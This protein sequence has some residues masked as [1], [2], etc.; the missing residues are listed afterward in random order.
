MMELPVFGLGVIGCGFILLCAIAA[1]AI[2]ALFL[3]LGAK[4]TGVQETYSKAFWAVF[5]IGILNFFVQIGLNRGKNPAELPLSLGSFLTEFVVS[6]LLSLIVGTVM[7]TW[8]YSIP[9][10]RAMLAYAVSLVL[11][12]LAGLVLLAMLFGI[13]WATVG[14]DEIDEVV[15]EA[16]Q[17][18]YEALRERAVQEGLDP[19]SVAP[20][21]IPVL[22]D[23]EFTE[24]ENAFDI[25][26]SQ[27]ERYIGKKVR[28]VHGSRR[29]SI[30]TLKEVTGTSLVVSVKIE[31]GRVE[32]P[33]QKSKIS[34]FQM[35]D[36]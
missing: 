9:V 32:L 8:I 26:V 29:E 30:G 23:V 28:I 7:V 34:T 4:M 33:I 35:I 10:L 16:K 25:E 22:E 36:D 20:E 3:H 14:T 5:A 21:A 19:S 12:F 18:Y 11:S 13:I 6:L 15:D 31:G 17:G 24:F 1:L 2:Q 27:A